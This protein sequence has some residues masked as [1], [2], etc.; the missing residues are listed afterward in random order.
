MLAIGAVAA[1]S[2][3]LFGP[4]DDLTPIGQLVFSLACGAALIG[5]LRYVSA[6]V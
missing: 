5:L 1:L 6:A 4:I 3:F 2:I